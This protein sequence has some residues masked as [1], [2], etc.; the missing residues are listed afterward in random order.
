MS[1][2]AWMNAL[3]AMDLS[4]M[5]V[6]AMCETDSPLKQVPHFDLLMKVR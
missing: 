4:Q 5:R 3:G 2:N 6:Q 1:S